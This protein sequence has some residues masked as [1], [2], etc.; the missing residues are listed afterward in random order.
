MLAARTIRDEMPSAN[1][2]VLNDIVLTKGPL[3]RIIEM[4]V[5]VGEA[6]VTRVRADGLIIATPT[7]STAYNLAAGGPIVP[8]A[9]DAMILT[10]LAPLTPPNRPGRSPGSSH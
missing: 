8:P 4:S 9:V 2:V 1:H 6:P 10:P 3:S 7:R 5:I